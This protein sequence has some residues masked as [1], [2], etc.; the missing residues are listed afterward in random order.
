MATQAKA[1]KVRYIEADKIQTSL[2]WTDAYK[3]KYKNVVL[4][5]EGE[6]TILDPSLK[7]VVK[8]IPHSP[9]YDSTVVLATQ[10]NTELRAGA[11]ATQEGIQASLRQ[12]SLAASN[13]FVAT[14]KELLSTI[15]DWK[16]TE[17]PAIRRTLSLNI[18]I[19]TNRLQ[20]RET[21]VRSSM[22]PHRYLRQR[23]IPKLMIDYPSRNPKETLVG[24]VT[25]QTTLPADRAFTVEGTA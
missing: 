9:G 23:W 17:D 6:M 11:L 10:Y 2:Q 15:E 20:A 21:D 16:Q 24:L 13:R 12:E 18:G 8:T 14:E 3:S 4:S 5:P 25:L 1:K 7:E 22:Y 19:L